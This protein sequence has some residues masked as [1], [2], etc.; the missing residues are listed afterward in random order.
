MNMFRFS[1]LLFVS[2]L[3]LLSCDDGGGSNN[4]T[5]ATQGDCTN[6]GTSE[7][8]INE[9]LAGDPD[10]GND[11]IELIAVG[12]E[13]NLVGWQL[14]DSNPAHVLDVST[15]AGKATL[16]AGER[17]IIE[18]D[19]TLLWGFGPAEM[20]SLLS[21]TGEIADET[22]WTTGSAS[23]G[24]TWCRIPD[25]EGAFTLCLPTRSAA[26][27]AMTTCGNAVVDAGEACDGD[28]S[29]S[30]IGFASGSLVC[31]DCASVD[32]SA[33]QP[34][35]SDLVIN[36]ASSL[37]DQVELYNAGSADV[38]L[39]GYTLSDRMREDATR[40]LRLGFITLTPGQRH[41]VDITSLFGL[42]AADVLTLRDPDAK[43]IDFVEWSG[44]AAEP[45]Y[46]RIPD[47]TGAFQ[48][49]AYTPGAAN[50]L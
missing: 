15:L 13:A 11:W 44:G 8:R 49:C 45:S 12:A 36:E 37:E 4:G 7:L 41:M 14:T 24:R 6:C 21:P 10:G 40:T 46:C 1:L 33:C 19:P 35:A 18:V 3:W 22:S 47:G 28:A 39:D 38:L 30:T 50:S 17:L 5:D 20:A 31:T 32:H 29:C 26:N 48:T 25:G 34:N 27:I 42:G 16:P 9:V 2:A 23:G 43:I